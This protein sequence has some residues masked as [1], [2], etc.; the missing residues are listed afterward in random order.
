MNLHSKARTC[1]ASRA[2]LVERMTSA[3]WSADQAA[4]ALGITTRTA[5]KWLARHRAE[6]SLGLRDRSSRPQRLARL[7]VEDRSELVVRLRRSR[8]TG[9]QIARRLRM[10][11]ST[12]AAILKRAGLARLRDL[13][14][15]QPIVRYERDRPGELIHL[16]I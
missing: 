16:D 7:T 1:P 9:Q 10:P 13:E 12:V 2:L 15:P 3:A 14:P 4:A 5:F 11:R 8:M 6:G